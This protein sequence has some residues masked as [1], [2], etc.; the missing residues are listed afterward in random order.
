[1]GLKTA[2][3]KTLS[4]W[5][6]NSKKPRRAVLSDLWKDDVLFFRELD[7]HA[8]VYYPHDVIGEQIT[9]TGAFSRASVKQLSTYL[10]QHGLA[11]EQGA[12][13]E[14][15][16]NIGTH[17]IYFDRDLRCRH[18][19]AI[20]PDPQNFALLKRNITLNGLGNKTTLL[21]LGASDQPGQL[22]FV[23]N[24]LNRGGSKI[25][26]T[27]KG[28]IMVDISTV[29][30]LVKEHKPQLEDLKLIWIDVE[31][32]E[33]QVLEGALNTLNSVA[34]PVF[35]EYTPASED[36]NNRLRDILFDAYDHVVDFAGTPTRL[37]PESFAGIHAQTDLLAFNGA[38]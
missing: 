30:T 2:F 36:R 27:G 22:P 12:I 29:D 9:R 3:S 25:G 35:M 15:G 23:L 24:A 8:L 10:A 26:D 7:D 28:A 5:V 16:A 20:E 4:R 37:T 31:G 34:P 18:V 1:M 19:V 11:I 17:T 38:E 14:I 13:L 32:H 6:L 33:L 21:Q